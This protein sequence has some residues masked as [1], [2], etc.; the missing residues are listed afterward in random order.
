MKRYIKIRWF[1]IERNRNEY[2]INKIIYRYIW[3]SI[4]ISDISSVSHNSIRLSTRKFNIP[5]HEWALQFNSYAES[6]KMHRDKLHGGGWYLEGTIPNPKRRSNNNLSTTSIFGDLWCFPV[7]FKKKCFP[8][9][10]YPG[11]TVRYDRLVSAICWKAYWKSDE[12]A[13]KSVTEV[14]NEVVGKWGQIWVSE[15]VETAGLSSKVLLKT[16]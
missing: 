5:I 9:L 14:T 1:I 12:C 4:L 6:R 8:L 11:K 13:S 15:G 3:P 16:A 10:G 7:L 2:P